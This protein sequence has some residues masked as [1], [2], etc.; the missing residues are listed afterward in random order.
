MAENHSWE[1]GSPTLECPIQNGFCNNQALAH[2]LLL[3]SLDAALCISSVMSKFVLLILGSHRS[4]TSALSGTLGLLGATLPRNLSG[5]T[6]ANEKGHFEPRDIANVHDELFR[7]LETAWSDW[8]PFPEGWYSSAECDDY[9]ERL[10]TIFRENY[11]D[12]DMAVLK[13][14]RINRLVPLWESVLSK[15]NI[16]P[17]VIIIN[18]NPFEVAKSLAARDGWSLPEALLIWLRNQLDA[19]F[20]TRAMKRVFVEYDA[21]ITDWQGVVEKIEKGLGISLL[22]RTAAVRGSIEEFLTASLRHQLLPPRSSVATGVLVEDW[23][24]EASG[25]L[26]AGRLD[27]KNA[28]SDLDKLR[29]KLDCATVALSPVVQQYR[30]RLQQYA[31]EWNRSAQGWLQER[32]RVNNAILNRQHLEQRLE[33]E[34]ERRKLVDIQVEEETSRRQAAERQIIEQ[35]AQSKSLEERINTIRASTSWRVTRPLRKLG[36]RWRSLVRKVHRGGRLGRG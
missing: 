13:E 10:A 26:R 34:V 25:I 15:L 32:E 29:S 28:M 23:A 3:L 2:E 6:A 22:Q 33:E 8:A 18:R 11:G 16:T 30:N 5:P 12:A 14:P 35:L 7:H 31:E 21:L 36:R 17:L 24:A 1:Q 20:S 19:E 4:G 9:I 27:C